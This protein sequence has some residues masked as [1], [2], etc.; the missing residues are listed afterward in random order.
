MAVMAMP[1][2]PIDVVPVTIH[3]MA[4]RIDQVT[5]AIVAGR[6]ARMMSVNVP[7]TVKPKVMR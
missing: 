2:A 4:V 1:A 7:R 6:I 3:V 5:I